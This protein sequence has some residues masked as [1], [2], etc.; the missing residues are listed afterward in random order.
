VQE[1]LLAAVTLVAS[2]LMVAY[3]EMPGLAA[4]SLASILI[5]GYLARER[6]HSQ[7]RWVWVAVAIGPFAIPI[8]SGGRGFR[9]QE[10]DG[11]ADGVLRAGSAARAD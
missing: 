1:L 4:A 11:C 7:W 8:V 2:V 3:T 5:V 6:G 9:F 10:N